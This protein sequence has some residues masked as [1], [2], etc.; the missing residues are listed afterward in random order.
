MWSSASK[1]WRSSRSLKRFGALCAL[2]LVVV[3]LNATSA[4]A[5]SALDRAVSSIPAH[6]L[7]TQAPAQ[8]VDPNRQ[9]AARY[10]A[11]S[12][13]P[14]WFVWIALQILVL[15]WLW[16][17]GRAARVRDWLR[18]AL[19][20][21][22]LVR[23]FFGAFL[24]LCVQ[25]VALPSQF[26]D[27]RILRIM[28]VSTQPPASFWSDVLLNL[29]IQIVLLGSAVALILWLVERTRLWWVYVMAGI[30]ATSFVLSSLYPVLIGPLFNH[31]ATLPP[32]RAL[33]KRLHVLAIKAGEGSLPIYVTDLSRRT[34]AGDAYVDGIGPSKRIV[35]GDTF[36]STATDDEIVFLVAHE[37]GH[38]V[39]HDVLRGTLFGAVLF[40]L[41]AAL[42][43]LIA[44][45]I[46]FRRD[47]DPMS[48]LALVGALLAC[49]YV[50]ML[51]A[52]N[53]Y[54][55]T[56][57]ASADRYAVR[58]DP[59]RVAGTRVFV[60]FADEGLA[61]LCPGRLARIF[62]YTHPPIGTRISAINGQPNPCP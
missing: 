35:I 8:L 15:L 33:T 59:D 24:A 48:R 10:F 46:G 5:Q 2:I 50:V 40:I 26:Y 49:M 54:S 16:R 1:S 11:R 18:R 51:P 19:P 31:F 17:S 7:L 57:E 61:L 34:K 25:G 60:R 39:H 62:W 4:H 45:R 9:E 22:G 58:L 36:L 43:V 30:F 37:L 53:G 20:T 47:D 12:T 23:F 21:T 28:G 13:R 32:D 27:Y 56:V 6:R 29:A 55:R 44:D 52:I 38:D 14:A 41:A 3:C 42:A